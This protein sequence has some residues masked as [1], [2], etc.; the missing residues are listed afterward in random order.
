M[1]GI[2]APSVGADTNN[3]QGF[4]TWVT[5]IPFSEI[6]T[7]DTIQWNSQ[8]TELTYKVFNKI[9]SLIS[10]H[11]QA[12]TISCAIVLGIGIY[13][14]CTRVSKDPWLSLLLFV[15][16]GLYQTA[17]NIT[18]SCLAAMFATIGCKYIPQGDLKR[19][20]LCVAIGCIFHY[21]AILYV[22]LFF[23]AKLR[24]RL[25]IVI[26]VLIGCFVIIPLAYSTVVPL[27]S[28]IV[29]S[30]WVQYLQV[31]RVSLSQLAVWGFLILIFAISALTS[32]KESV[33]S[34]ARIN[35]ANMF[36]LVV[37]VFY[38]F[39]I[40]STS[41]SRVAVLFAPY[42]IIAVPD[43]LSHTRG[44]LINHRQ[45]IANVDPTVATV[46]C[47]HAKAIAVVAV[48]CIFVLRL[49][50]NNIGLTLPYAVFF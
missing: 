3:Y 23:I 5:T 40:C 29:P 45:S 27:I 33:N 18:P 8:D 49:A 36:L 32:S 14:L 2:R 47:N 11:P 7:A 24:F 50:V 15:C 19:F 41:F 9:I 4:F 34:D 37:G 39:T 12:I 6:V 46:N 31:E 22:P 20:L 26:P 48:S 28:N 43:Y 21:A 10:T 38:A 25:R 42:F 13:I 35:I 30:R 16:F 17:M 1:A 44:A